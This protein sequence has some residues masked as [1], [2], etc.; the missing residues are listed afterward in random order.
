MK[1]GTSSKRS[2]GGETNQSD[3][4]LIRNLEAQAK[5]AN[6]S[7]LKYFGKHLEEFRKE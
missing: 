1:K 6:R 3:A 2:A 5:H 7:I 4:D